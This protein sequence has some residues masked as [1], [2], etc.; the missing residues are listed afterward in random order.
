MD[1]KEF[2]GIKKCKK[3]LEFTEFTVLIGRNNSGKSSILG[4]LSLLPFPHRSFKLP[5]HDENRVKLLTQ[6]LGGRSSLV[7][8]YSGSATI[9]YAINKRKWTLTLDEGG[10]P[11]LQIENIPQRNMINNYSDS[12]ALALGVKPGTFS[13]KEINKKVFFIPND[14]S[15]LEKIAKALQQESNQN[16]VIKAGAHTRVAKLINECVDD[17]Y[18]EVLFAPELRLRKEISDNILYI[19]IKDLGDGIK[20]IAILFMWLEALK[21]SLILWD[22]FEG[23]AH[24]ALIKRVLDWLNRGRKQYKWQVILSTHNIDVLNTLLDLKPKNAKVIQTKK[25]AND[26]LIYQSL[27]LEELEDLFDANQDPRKLVDLLEI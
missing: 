3:P 24:P 1:I 11:S 19:K 20:K 6:L 7:Y 22:D 8:A 12:I 21:P 10:E 18:S 25:T 13:Y 9:E 5:Y 26:V 23:S 4:A 16:F 15:F 14:T 2:R 17:E 27:N